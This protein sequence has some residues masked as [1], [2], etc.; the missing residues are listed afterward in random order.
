MEQ[1]MLFT[2][3]C[4]FTSTE[5]VRTIRD[6]GPRSATSTFTDTAPEP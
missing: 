2:F 3:Q 4:W 1:F 5:T 6:G